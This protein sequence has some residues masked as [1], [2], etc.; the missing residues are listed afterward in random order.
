MVVGLRLSLVLR[1]EGRHSHDYSCSSWWDK[2]TGGCWLCR[3]YN[4]SMNW[5]KRKAETVL[6]SVLTP[7]LWPFLLLTLQWSSPLPF[8]F[9]VLNE[10]LNEDLWCDFHF[11]L[12]LILNLSDIQWWWS[13]LLNPWQ[14]PQMH[15]LR[16]KSSPLLVL[17]L[18]RKMFFIPLQIQP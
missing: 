17:M 16:P 1:G 11:D 10:Q 9:G 18:F 13:H 3:I 4:K 8:Y 2:K 7:S 12:C 14:G 6:F 15:F 5:T